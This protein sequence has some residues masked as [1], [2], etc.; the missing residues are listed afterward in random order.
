MDRMAESSDWRRYYASAAGRAPRPHLRAAL[1]HVQRPGTAID[2][3][4]GDGVDSRFLLAEGWRVVAIDKTPGLGERIGLDAGPRLDA[5]DTTFADVDDLPAADLVF[6][7]YSLPFATEAEFTHVWSQL[8]AA[9]VPGG[10]FA[11]QLFGD[12][13]DW[14]HLDDVRTHTAEQVRD[15]LAGWHVLLLD[16]VERDGP[17]GRGPK[18]WHVFDIIAR[19]R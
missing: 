3:G 15:L 17:S 16:E 14:A 12:R 13:D 1:S 6:A 4:A 10:V 9:L 18:H 5:R 2:L 11:G 19:R 8:T 7:G